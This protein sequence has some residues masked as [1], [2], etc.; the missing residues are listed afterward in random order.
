MS[1]KFF[2]LFFLISFPFFVKEAN[3][4]IGVNVYPT[5]GTAGT[6]VVITATGAGSTASLVATKEINGGS[7]SG[8]CYDDFSYSPGAQ[9]WYCNWDTTGLTL[10]T[11]QIKLRN[12]QIYGTV[13]A[14]T[15]YTVGSVSTPTP[16]AS[17]VVINCGAEGQACCNYAIIENAYCD[18][19]LSCFSRQGQFPICCLPTGGGLCA[20]STQT[21][22][23]TPTAS[24]FCGLLEENC[25]NIKG[26]GVGTCE[27][28]LVC[29]VKPPIGAVCCPNGYYWDSGSL[30]CRTQTTPTPTATPGVS[31]PNGGLWMMLLAG[32][33]IP[34]EGS[35][36]SYAL[37]N[38]WNMSPSEGIIDGFDYVKWLIAGG[39][40]Q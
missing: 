38:L 39:V 6:R 1:K 9:E 31:L 14:T 20:S 29:I 11:Y 21:P 3:A 16:T 32:N 13:L 17:P 27:A 4:A 37:Y 26:P 33:T 22:T 12:A 40:L 24:P 15:T 28:G 34:V 36:A 18:T 10:G 19:G 5:S 23:P 8:A 35:P 7:P 25:C 2:V 30:Q